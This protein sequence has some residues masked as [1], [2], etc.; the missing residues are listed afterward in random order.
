MTAAR[1]PVRALS[2]RRCVVDSS[3]RMRRLAVAGFISASAVTVAVAPHAAACE[4]M[5]FWSRLSDSAVEVATPLSLG[6]FGGAFVAP[7]AMA[8]TG[9]DYQLRRLA[10]K[11]LHGKPDA[12]PISV[13][14]PFVLPGIVFGVDIAALATEEC[15]V[16]RPSSA[17]LQA[18]GV[19]LVAVTGFKFATG[20]TW[21][22]AGRNPS[23][24]DYYE[25]PES[26]RQFNW[27]SWQHGHAW[28]SGHTAIMVSAATALSTVEY[29]RSW[30]GYVAYGAAAAVAAGMWLGNHHWMSDIV[31]GALLGGSIGRSV[32]LAFR[33]DRPQGAGTGLTVTPYFSHDTYGVQAL[34][35]W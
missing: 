17:M 26:S 33:R 8:P 31:S 14:T 22:A 11:G 25:H 12:E 13:W 32:G 15:E 2:G 35:R 19:T 24:P 27:F 29:G 3:G 21:P 10:M 20:R 4:N 6:L 9:A 1:S 7:L 28:P 30:L 34:A 5:M 18:M 16:A 23:A